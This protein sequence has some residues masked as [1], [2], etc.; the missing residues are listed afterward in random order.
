MTATVEAPDALGRLL[1]LPPSGRPAVEWRG[2]T[3]T[4]AELATRVDE[5]TGTLVEAGAPGTHVLLLGPLCPAYVVGLLACLRAGAVPVPTD[6][7][8]APDRYAWAERIA[9]PSAILTSDVS[10]VAHYRGRAGDGD[11]HELV[12][13]AATG[14]VVLTT[15]PWHRRQPPPARR[16]Q[17]MDAG[18]LIPTSG[19]TGAP[20]AIV[21]SRRGLHAFLSWFTEEFAFGERD[22]C[23]AVTRVNFDP[24]LRELLGVLT[25]GGTLCLPEVD[26]QLD[27]RTLGAHLA[28]SR[29]TLAFL[30]PSLARRVGDA[31]RAESVRLDALRL[32]F[33]AGEVLPARVVEQWSELAPGAEF[34]NL[35]G[36]TEGTL[37][38][39]FR[40]GVRVGRAGAEAAGGAA[41]GVPVGRPR[42]GVSV[43]IDRPDADGHGEVLVASSAPALGTLADGA[44]GAPGTF[45]VDPMPTPLRTGDIGRRTEG[46]ELMVVGRLGDDLKVSGRRVAYHRFVDDVEEL[47]GV[48]QCVVVD[49][50]G[51]HAFVAAARL[52]PGQEE[53]LSEQVRDVAKRHGLPVPAV[54]PRRELPLLRSG[55]VDRVALAT[56]VE[57]SSGTGGAPPPDPGATVTD[58]LLGLLGLR[59]D[60]AAVGAAPDATSFVDAGLSSL[61]MMDFVGK[62]EQRF[63][64]VLSVQECF[65]HR[66]VASLARAIERGGITGGTGQGSGAESDGHTSEGRRAAPGRD[67][68]AADEHV[69]EHVVPLSTRQVAYMAICMADGNAN[70]CNLSREIRIDRALTTDEVRAAADL[71]T[72]RHD[73]LR[74]SLTPDWSQQVHSEPD[75]VRCP[76]TVHETPGP[77]EH[78]ARVQQARAE[79]VAQ[80]IDPAAPPPMRVV[81]V[82][83]DGIT[84]VVLVAHHLFLDGLS[85]DLI[86]GELRSALQGSALDDAP[87]PSGYRVYCR[88]TR[89]PDRPAPA[90]AY[91]R[92]F[93]RD[94]EQITLPEATGDDARVGELV[95]RPFGVTCSRAAHRIAVATGVSVFPVVLAAFDLAVSRTFGLDRLSIVVP[96]QVRDEVAAATAGMFM[97]QLVVRG[98]DA[99]SLPDRASA[100]AEQ[101]RVGTASSA[102]EF[103]QRIEELGLAGAD[104]FP[105]S[106]VLF[107]QHPKR[108][109]LRPRDLGAWQPRSLGR[110]LR[111]QLQG[112]LQVSASEMAL[113]YYYRRGIAMDRTD[114]IDRLHSEVLA[115]LQEA[116][117]TSCAD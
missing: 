79:A 48:D 103:D 100:Y 70:W 102:W 68:P 12:L 54:H 18:Y 113:T 7:G 66:D 38:Q 99:V 5:L 96:V 42:P 60:P 86:A 114:V 21:G 88:A 34:V 67:R 2:E 115:A 91:W 71:L 106:T 82:P 112:E 13:D 107:N 109:G 111:Y 64:T 55:K 41:F 37:A 9:R 105:L 62:V 33:F 16:H 15:A 89:R 116:G 45:R 39:L 25:A 73:V 90:A 59:E 11:L 57:Q 32:G 20:K 83:G 27:P 22:V 52:Q 63:G 80:L 8:L 47:V 23:A 76:V 78:R 28:R 58:V 51:P 87:P 6:A 104:R 56:S 53:T 35:Y 43:E 26:A 117:R 95:S 24:S 94:A 61:D 81:V 4:Y 92:T 29:A 93:L 97:S 44:G 49:R 69:G 50:Q 77:G 17:D 110:T 40:R 108:R 1:D 65:A 98:P 31:L 14:R 85:M 84:S 101:L 75:A 10:A 30:V 72:R 3:L 46:G 19:S 74:L 36:M